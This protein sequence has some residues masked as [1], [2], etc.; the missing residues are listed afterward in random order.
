M[1]NRRR[2]TVVGL[3]LCAAALPVGAA[4][5]FSA[6]D[7]TP[8]HAFLRHGQYLNGSPYGGCTFGLLEY[9]YN[10]D[11]PISAVLRR[12]EG[13][14]KSAGYRLHTIHRREGLMYE[15]RRTVGSTHDTAVVC[16]GQFRYVDYAVAGMRL[17]ERDP[18]KEGTSI[19]FGIWDK[20]PEWLQ[21]ASARLRNALN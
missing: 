18:T 10:F 4:A 19:H 13:E 14:L 17:A 11:E 21:E 3:L 15:W 6:T 9:T 12:A 1:V 20:R 16:D 5:V 7:Q 2:A 8:R